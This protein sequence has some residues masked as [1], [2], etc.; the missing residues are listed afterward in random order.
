[1]DVE[2][3]LVEPSLMFLNL[4]ENVFYARTLALFLEALALHYP[5]LIVVRAS[6]P[7]DLEVHA[8]AN[9][10]RRRRARRRPCHPETARQ[11]QLPSQ[12]RAPSPAKQSPSQHQ[13]CLKFLL[14][15]IIHYSAM[16]SS[17]VQNQLSMLNSVELCISSPSS[18]KS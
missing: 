4:V 13:L 9:A 14:Y 7:R 3:D 11:A 6:Y 17:F 10:D 16:Y 18:L 15:S 5:N 8:G 1:M 12:S 2:A